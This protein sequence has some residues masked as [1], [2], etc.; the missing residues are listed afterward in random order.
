MDDPEPRT[1]A[2]HQWLS[3]RRLIGLDVAAAVAYTLLM[4]LIVGRRDGGV[5]APPLELLVVL[6]TG[7][8]P[9]VRRLWPVWVFALVLAMSVLG[10]ALRLP[11]D[12]FGA[13]AF[14]LYPVAL[15][16]PRRSWLPTTLIGAL[17]GTVL[18]LGLVAGPR[19]QGVDTYGN[20]LLGLALMGVSWTIGRAV[21]ERRATAA[22][23]VRQLAGRAV[24]EERLRIA[25]EMHDVVAHSMSLIA[26]KAGV[27]VHVAEARPQEALDALRVIEDTSRS[28]LAE[29]RHLLGVLRTGAAD[30]ADAAPAPVPGLTGLPRLVDAAGMAGVH[31]DLRISVDELPEGIALAVHRIVQEALTNIVKHAAPAR[32]RVVVEQDAREVR[33]EVTDDG[34]GVRVLPGAASGHGL[35]GMRERAMMY[36]GDLT[37][38]PRPEGGFAVSARLP[39]DRSDP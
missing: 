22:H 27:A 17:S 2:A 32:G 6:L 10:I 16:Q 7:L 23:A 18:L 34:P 26:V 11:G 30:P 19:G 14:S 37:A 4:L 31:V 35:I 8:P 20:A 15:S 29:M 12:F 33:V 1:L 39:C 13:A 28:A 25:R 5:A 36:G 21:R 38:G 3:R 9:A 24:T